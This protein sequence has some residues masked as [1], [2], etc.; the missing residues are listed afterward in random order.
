MSIVNCINRYSFI[1]LSVLFDG[2]FLCLLF[3][4]FTV[5]TPTSR[6]KNLELPMFAQQPRNRIEPE[7]EDKLRQIMKHSGILEINSVQYKTDINDLIDVGELGS[8]TSGHVVRMKHKPTDTVIAVKVSDDLNI[9][10][11]I[12]EFIM[13]GFC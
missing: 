5:G 2:P 8:G 13:T 1:Y 9:S 11:S 4:I 10:S 6:K 12:I 7:T 3:Y